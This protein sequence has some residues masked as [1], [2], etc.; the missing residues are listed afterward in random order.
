M[1]LYKRIQNAEIIDVV[2][3]L[4]TTLHVIEA[5]SHSFRQLSKSD[6]YCINKADE[7]ELREAISSMFS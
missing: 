3:V 2:A 7:V 6:T 5:V 1:F 4:L